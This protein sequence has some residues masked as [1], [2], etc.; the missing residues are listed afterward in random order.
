MGTQE[1]IHDPVRSHSS[2]EPTTPAYAEHSR[3]FLVST[4]SST[5]GSFHNTE[6]GR[7]YSQL[8]VPRQCNLP[9][10]CQ[11]HLP[12]ACDLEIPELSNVSEVGREKSLARLDPDNI[13]PGHRQWSYRSHVAQ[14]EQEGNAGVGVM[15]SSTSLESFTLLST[16]TAMQNFPQ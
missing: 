15:P 1:I 12:Y 11:A 14:V 4:D 16:H 2:A 3:P 9:S 7:H 8:D 5:N 13:V 6:N 10:I